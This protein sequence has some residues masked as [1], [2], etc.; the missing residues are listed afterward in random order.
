[1]RELC[2]HALA[3][4]N[5]AL[6]PIT[7]TAK[8]RAGKCKCMAFICADRTTCRV[9]AILITFLQSHKHI[10]IVNAESLYL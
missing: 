9:L 5:L 3:F 6:E 4:C 1:M 7:I 8:Q 2:A 10:Y